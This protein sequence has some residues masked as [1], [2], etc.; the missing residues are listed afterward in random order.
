MADQVEN[1]EAELVAT[2]PEEVVTETP[3]AAHKAISA[4]EAAP[5]VAIPN[6][7]FHEDGEDPFPDEPFPDNL[8]VLRTQ[9]SAHGG[10][11]RE[12]PDGTVTWKPNSYLGNLVTAKNLDLL[13][14]HLP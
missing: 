3:V 11:I 12:N 13:I 2:Q 9:S 14:A 6:V 10:Y 7:I 1:L 5:E 4:E 8:R